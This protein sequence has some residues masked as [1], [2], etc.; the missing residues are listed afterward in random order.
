[1]SFGRISAQK[2][3]KSKADFCHAPTQDMTQHNPHGPDDHPKT[4][5]YITIWTWQEMMV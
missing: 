4:I 2:L 5:D 1:M 3:G